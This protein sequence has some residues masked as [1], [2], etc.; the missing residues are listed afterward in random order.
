MSVSF[1]MPGPMVS[2]CEAFC[3]V[4]FSFGSLDSAMLRPIPFPA[5]PVVIATFVA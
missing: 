1:Y 2:I 5:D 4:F 3:A